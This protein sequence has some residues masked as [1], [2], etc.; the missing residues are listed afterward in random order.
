MVKPTKI[1]MKMRAI[2]LE[3]EPEDNDTIE[4]IVAYLEGTQDHYR[5]FY[6]LSRSIVGD[7][8]DIPDGV[9][10]AADAETSS[11]TGATEQPTRGRRGRKSKNQPDPA[12]AVA[13][14]PAPIPGVSVPPVPAAPTAPVDSAP[15]ANGIP[16]FLDRQ[17]PNAAA[18]APVATMAPPPPPAPAAPAPAAPAPAPKPP[19]GTLAPK[20]VAELRGRAT[21]SA[22]GGKGLVDWLAG[23]ALVVPNATFDE[24]MECL[25]FLDDAKLG[26][27]ATAL[28][29]S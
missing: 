23:A 17:N 10:V 3:I 5:E 28:G 15:N 24:A 18:N 11:D 2:E 12:T 14:P 19:V 9:E 27:V 16:A 4:N 1:I 22:D 26:P 6:R 21:G 7:N 25:Q 13:P 8:A 20:I 29:V